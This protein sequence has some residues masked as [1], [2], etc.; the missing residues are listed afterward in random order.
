M[1][2][3][4]CTLSSTCSGTNSLHKLSFLKEVATKWVDKASGKFLTSMCIS[5]M[6]PLKI[7]GVNKQNVGILKLVSYQTLL[8]PPTYMCVLTHAYTHT[9]TFFPL[10]LLINIFPFFLWMSS[11]LDVSNNGVLIR[12]DRTCSSVQHILPDQ[13]WCCTGVRHT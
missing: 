5:R 12:I 8:N 9:H 10:L 11:S 7:S 13:L 6:I 2:K 4:E 3:Q 1:E